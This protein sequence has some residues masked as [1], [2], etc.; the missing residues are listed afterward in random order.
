[1][2]PYFQVE[3]DESVLVHYGVKGMKWGV[4]RTAQQL[5]NAVSKRIKKSSEK[6]AAIKATKKSYAQDKGPQRF[7]VLNA[8]NSAA[9]TYYRKE[10]T[11]N[12]ARYR[13]QSQVLDR[14]MARLTEEQVKA[15]RYRVSRA[16][17]VKRQAFSAVV[18]G[19]AGL[20]L[21]ASGAG[22]VGIP[23]AAAVS[24]ASH[25]ASGGHYYW[26]E[27]RAYG[28]VRAKYQ[29]QKRVTNKKS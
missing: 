10:R 19:A 23:A 17:Y 4:R 26:K 18:G 29:N 5:G 12:F 21:I 20:G 16:R 1:M 22:V 8:A 25:F 14:K 3:N 13:R 2:T 24:A 11:R 6:R 9:R 27:K 15:G 28:D 7:K